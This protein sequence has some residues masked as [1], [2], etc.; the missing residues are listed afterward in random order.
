MCTYRVMSKH[1]EE[2]VLANRHREPED[3]NV[4]SAVSPVSGGC[5]CD[6]ICPATSS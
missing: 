5:D 4:S 2:K 3:E 6:V 1:L